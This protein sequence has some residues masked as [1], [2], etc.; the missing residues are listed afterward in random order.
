MWD[1]LYGIVLPAESVSI[2]VSW[3]FTFLLLCTV[4]PDVLV[5]VLLGGGFYFRY[6]LFIEGVTDATK[7]NPEVGT[8]RY[9][10]SC[11]QQ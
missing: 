7:M 11:D 5:S 10:H 6:R 8:N 1:D 2:S 4:Q 3:G 9:R